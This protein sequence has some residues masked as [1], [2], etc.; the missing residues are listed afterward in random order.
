MI[1]KHRRNFLPAF[2]LNFLLWLSWFYIVFKI[3]PE[4]NLPFTVY[5]LPFTIPTGHLLFFLTLTLSLTLTFA[6]LF[7]STRRGFFLSLF[8]VI[9][10]ILRLIKQAHLLNLILLGGI[11]ICSEIYSS[12]RKKT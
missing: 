7:S 1:L 3:P 6:F 5:H 11:L 12:Q 2:F 4:S 9:S 8:I 10:L